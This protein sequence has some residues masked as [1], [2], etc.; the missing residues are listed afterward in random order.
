MVDEI[1]A[2]FN[3]GGGKKTRIT[4]LV[5]SFPPSLADILSDYGQNVSASNCELRGIGLAVEV[6]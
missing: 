5:R 1:Y 6:I 2:Y 3:V 4:A